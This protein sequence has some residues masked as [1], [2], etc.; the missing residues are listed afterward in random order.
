[1][2]SNITS[3][4]QSQKRIYGKYKSLLG[5]YEQVQKIYTTLENENAKL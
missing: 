1:M 4:A 2:H 3:I 5:N